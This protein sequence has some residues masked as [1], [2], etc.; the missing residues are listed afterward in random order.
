[1]SRATRA[2]NVIKYHTKTTITNYIERKKL[3]NL[4]RATIIIFIYIYMYIYVGKIDVVVNVVSSYKNKGTKNLK[5]TENTSLIYIYIC[6]CKKRR[7]RKIKETRKWM[8]CEK[9]PI[10]V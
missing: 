1:M 9:E 2:T 5:P 3:N 8:R 7:K 4:K 6:I 10:Y